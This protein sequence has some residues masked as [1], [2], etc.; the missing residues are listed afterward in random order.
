MTHSVSKGGDAGCKDGDVPQEQKMR[1]PAWIGFSVAVRSEG[2]LHQMLQM[3]LVEALEAR[4]TQQQ[5]RT[6]NPLP[7]ESSAMSSRM[8]VFV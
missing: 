3:T 2:T 6:L 7:L 1:F 8:I 4:K 5:A